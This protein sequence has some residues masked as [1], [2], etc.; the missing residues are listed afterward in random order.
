[1]NM[2]IEEEQKHNEGSEQREAVL[3]KYWLYIQL[4]HENESE[5][6]LPD[7]SFD[8]NQTRQ[9]N[10]NRTVLRLKREI[11]R[12]AFAFDHRPVGRGGSRGFARTPH[13]ASKDF[14]YTA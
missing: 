3:T 8:M 9:S 10:R 12:I 1:M 4:N 13:L 2:A 5:G 6:L 11:Y 7:S 14:I